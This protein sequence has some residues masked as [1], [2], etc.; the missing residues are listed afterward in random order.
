MDDD[1]TPASESDARI[2]SITAD[3]NK[4]VSLP[5][6]ASLLSKF[7]AANP[8][9][10][11]P[12]YHNHCAIMMEQIDLR[13]EAESLRA[14]AKPLSMAWLAKLCWNIVFD[15]VDD[16]WIYLAAKV[17]ALIHTYGTSTSLI[18]GP[19]VTLVSAEQLLML[20]S[21]YFVHLFYSMVNDKKN[22]HFCMSDFHGDTPK[23]QGPMWLRAVDSI[24][25][26]VVVNALAKLERCVFQTARVCACH[27][28]L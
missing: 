26:A 17:E 24:R 3:I 5:S 9:G 7:L 6:V 14:G 16:A 21:Q 22:K 11:Q 28:S 23:Q 10:T 20:R 12:K 27:A 25:S 8:P 2:A 13:I 18:S 1:G 19:V 4:I 15:S